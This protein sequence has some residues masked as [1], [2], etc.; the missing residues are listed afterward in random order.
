MFLLSFISSLMSSSKRKQ[1]VLVLV[2]SVINK[3]S[4]LTEWRTVLSV[5]I[6]GVVKQNRGNP[7]CLIAFMTADKTGRHEVLL[8]NQS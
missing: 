8:S 3:G 4:I 1:K 5:I 2:L 6:I 7:I